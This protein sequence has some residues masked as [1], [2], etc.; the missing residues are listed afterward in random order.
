MKHTSLKFAGAALAIAATAFTARADVTLTPN[1]SAYG[2]VSTLADYTQYGANGVN[3]DSTLDVNAAKLG[4]AFNFAPV[5]AKISFYTTPD[6]TTVLE[7]NATYDFGQGLSVTGG[8]FQSWLGYEPFDVP[9][10]NFLTNGASDFGKKNQDLFP[11]FH[12]GVHVD[13]AFGKNTVG[14]AVVDSIYTGNNFYQ[15]DGKLSDGYGIEAH[16]GFNDGPLS[17]GATGAYQNTRSN[18]TTFDRVNTWTNMYVGDIWAQ[19]II[20]QKTTIG[21]EL[22]YKRG[23]ENRRDDLTQYYGLVSVKQQI[24]D[25]FSV[26][27]RVSAGAFDTGGGDR[28]FW[29]I[30]V[31][32]AYAATKYL[33]LAGEINYSKYNNKWAGTGKDNDMYVGVLA[34]F[35][36]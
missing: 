2:Y 33:V 11:N 12:E 4:F 32:P 6:V 34:C 13:Y 30:S 1:V 23:V 7:A 35:H 29:K 19:Y 16:Y 24:T 25:Q 10:C 9:N 28:S 20:D 31:T 14:V 18:N 8:R 3:S 17:I 15:G 27:G 36:F 26:A 5:T 22:A 21:A